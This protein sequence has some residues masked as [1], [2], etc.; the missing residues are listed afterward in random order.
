L[1]GT[2]WVDAAAPVDSTVWYVVRARNN[3]SC[4]G[5]LGVDD[6]NLVRLD[7]TETSSTSLPGPVGDTLIGARFGGAGARLEWAPA[8][9]A[10]HYAVY[11]GEN[12]DLTDA[13][14][15]GTTAGTLFED[16]ED[17]AGAIGFYRALAVDACEREE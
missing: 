17:A 4:A 6:G 3:E 14:L 2:S 10:D 13:V 8:P 12:A 5:D 16:L 7:G 9:A 1:T 15:I 11:R